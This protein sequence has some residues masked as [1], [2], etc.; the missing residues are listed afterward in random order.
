MLT[1]QTYIYILRVT[2]GAIMTK[3][4]PAP[5]VA[6]YKEGK[7]PRVIMGVNNQ[8]NGQVVCELPE[9]WLSEKKKIANTHLIAAAPELLEALENVDRLLKS[10]N[11]IDK[12]TWIHDEV[13]KAIK[14]ARGHE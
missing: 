2:K 12:N 7:N 5:W 14:K 8:W 6:S 10:I 13:I 11:R 3:H 1:S 9:S 4:T